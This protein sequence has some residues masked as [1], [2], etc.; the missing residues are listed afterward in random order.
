MT[1]G[2]MLQ[3]LCVLTPEERRALLRLARDSIRCAVLGGAEPAVVPLTEALQAPGA[4][5]VSLHRDGRLRGC[6]GTLRA[7]EPLYR[8]VLHVARSAALEDPRF[9][10]LSAPELTRLE[11]EISRLSA[12]VPA[13]P[14]DVQPGRHGV[15]VTLGACRAVLLP[16]V[17]T[18]HGWD[19]DTLLT[20][21]CVKAMLPPD[22]W[23]RADATLQVF[24]AEVF[25]DDGG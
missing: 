7:D 13:R 16:Q 10:P 12:L 8:T 2:P 3:L 1:A 17:A 23:R 15:A 25:A 18:L 9:A 5:F 24:E 21:V 22:A 11:I 19:R 14:A 4:A 6:I 20:E